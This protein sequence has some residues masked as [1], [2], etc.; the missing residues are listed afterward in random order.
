MRLTI[1]PV[2]PLVAASATLLALFVVACA[3]THPENPALDAFPAGVAGSTDVTHYDVHGTT[4]RELV[5]EMRRF[6]PKTETGASFFGETHSPLR[7]EWKTRHDG[8]SCTTSDISVYVRSEITLP[9]WTPP[10]DA[11]P[12]LVEQWKQFLAALETHEIGHKDISARAARDVLTA[13]RRLNTMCT[14]FSVEAK[15][16]TDGIVARLRVEQETY[17]AQTRHGATQGATFPPRPIAGSAPPE[18]GR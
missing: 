13:I 9:K 18:K 3:T 7:W 15:R 10:S 6:G 1:I 4:A 2:R 8:P 5:A 12:A 11:P 17:D 16:V 14:S